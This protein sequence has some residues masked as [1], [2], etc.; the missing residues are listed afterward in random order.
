MSWNLVQTVTYCKERRLHKI[1]NDFTEH[2]KGV[3]IKRQ[4]VKTEVRKILWRFKKTELKDAIFQIS[5]KVF[6]MIP[7]KSHLRKIRN[8]IR[9]V[10][11]T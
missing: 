4:M 10:Q 9:T 1:K 11:E 6:C 8:K 3:S 2:M 5:N 7:H